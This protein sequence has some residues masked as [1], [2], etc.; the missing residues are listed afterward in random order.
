MTSFKVDAGLSFF[1]GRVIGNVSNRFMTLRN[2][3]LLLEVERQQLE[4]QRNLLQ[5]RRIR[6]SGF[7]RRP[8]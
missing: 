8:S 5:E 4:A 2:E 7:F 1:L 3:V 6:V